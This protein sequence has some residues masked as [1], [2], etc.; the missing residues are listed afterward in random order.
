MN[1]LGLMSGIILLII[2]LGV[3]PIPLAITLSDPSREVV[4]Y[5][6]VLFAVPLILLSALLLLYGVTTD[7]KTV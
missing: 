1:K 4:L 7:K 2:A 6:N 3:S 5:P